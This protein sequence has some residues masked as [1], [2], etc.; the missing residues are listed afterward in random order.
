MN[1]YRH[2]F[3][4]QK[5][6]FYAIHPQMIRVAKGAQEIPSINGKDNNQASRL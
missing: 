3:K 1:L 5:T 2:P 6:S 4:K